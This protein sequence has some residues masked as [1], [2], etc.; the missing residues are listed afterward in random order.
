[1]FHISS[2]IVFLKKPGIHSSRKAV[3][4]DNH[5]EEGSRGQSYT[6]ILRNF[7]RLS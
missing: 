2:I 7:G 4:E 6:S 1:M 3:T 5:I